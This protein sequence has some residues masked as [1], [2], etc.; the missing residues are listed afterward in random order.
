MTAR[1]AWTS[2][3]LSDVISMEF[4]DF[5]AKHPE[6]SDAAVRSQRDRLYRRGIAV[7][8][9][10]LRV[11]KVAVGQAVAVRRMHQQADRN[12]G[13]VGLPGATQTVVEDPEDEQYEALFR[14]LEDVDDAVAVLSP[15][16]DSTEFHAPDDGLPVGVAFSGDWHLGASGVDSKR[17]LADLETIGQTEG[18]YAVGMGDFVEGVGIHTKAASA[19]YSGLLNSGNLQ[20]VYALLRMQRAAGKWLA[21]VSGNHDEWMARS[22]GVTRID[23]LARQLGARGQ[24]P[25]HFCQGGGTIFAHVGGQRYVIAVTHNAKW[26]SQLNTSNAQRRTFD[27]WPQWE[28]CD[29]ICCGHLHYTDLHHQTRKGGKCLYLRSGTYK[30]KDGYAADH[31]YK[32]EYGVPV[33]ILY[34]GERKVLGFRGDYFEDAIRFLAA[35]RVRYRAG[36]SEEDIAA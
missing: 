8:G 12:L 13:L 3:Q 1:T 17:L 33:A 35:E 4:T 20:E 28:S 15:T 19:L 6:F 31:G 21:L 9:H 7:N 32:P 29:V 22:S 23:R 11:D 27:G 34:P 10:P 14:L 2:K 24:R 26:N 25:P 18:L 16:Q 30:L 36:L 5:K